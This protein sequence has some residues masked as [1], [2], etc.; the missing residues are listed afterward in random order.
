MALRGAAAWMMLVTASAV[1]T[2]HAA[3]FDPQRW[4]AHIGDTLGAVLTRWGQSATFGADCGSW[5]GPS[6]DMAMSW[7]GQE[8][9]V[10]ALLRGD[11][12]DGLR[13]ERSGERST[14]LSQCQL[15]LDAFVKDWTGAEALAVG[16]EE[17]LFDGPVLRTIRPALSN[18]RVVGRFEADYRASR[19]ECRLALMRT[20]P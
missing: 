2:A 14:A 15:Q 11:R 9:R 7:Q 6:V 20:A 8:L 16:T 13:F 19:S 3:G 4:P 18:N 12:V 1:S 5:R 10:M 17:L